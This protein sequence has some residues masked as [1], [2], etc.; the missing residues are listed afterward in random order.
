MLI[1]IGKEHWINP[2]FIQRLYKHVESSTLAYTIW[3]ANEKI[4]ISKSSVTDFYSPTFEEILSA[5][6]KN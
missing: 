3:I 4:E 5:S 2:E 1:Q 6:S